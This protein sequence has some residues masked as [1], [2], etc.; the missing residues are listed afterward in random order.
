MAVPSLM[1]LGWSFVA[2]AAIT[3]PLYGLGYGLG[4]ALLSRVHRI[5]LW[6]RIRIETRWAAYERL[7]EAAKPADLTTRLY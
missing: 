3:A 7:T 1:L 5:Q 4:V 2:R 6:P